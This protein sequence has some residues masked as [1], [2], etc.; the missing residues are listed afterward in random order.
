MK[1]KLKQYIKNIFKAFGVEI[2]KSGYSNSS[3]YALGYISAK[4]TIDVSSKSGLSVGDYLETIWD[5]KDNRYIII[6]E[7]NKFGIFNINI[8]NICEIGTGAGLYAEKTAEL[9]QP[10]R[11]ESYEPDKDWAE[12]LTKKYNIISHDADGKS[13]SCTQ[14]SSIDLVLAH[15]VFVYLPFL[16]TY[17][18]FQEIV[19]VTNDE[20]YAVFD[21]LS[22]ECFDDNTLKSWVDSEQMFPCFLSEDYIIEFFTK[23]RFS[24]IGEF[25]NHKFNVGKSKY[26]I[27]KKESSLT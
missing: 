8:K 17:R 22:E 9:C 3:P 23:H 24:L 5:Q 21:I 26:L 20:G 25:F 27:F 6:D 19:R 2:H 12:W 11:Y 4:E 13:L 1:T 14:T 10:V 15:G 18:Y 7:L 16:L